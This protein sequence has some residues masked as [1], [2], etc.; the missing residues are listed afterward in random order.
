MKYTSKRHFDGMR[1]RVNI[2][3]ISYG[4]RNFDINKFEEIQNKEYCNKPKGGLWASPVD[5]EHGWK[6]WC[7]T[8]QFRD[9]K[10]E[11]SFR[12]TLKD[13]ANIY[14]INR[15]DDC[16]DM[17]QV[18]HDYMKSKIYPD[19]EI[20]KQNGVDAIQ[21]NLSNDKTESYSDGLYF[22]LYGWDCDC[23]LVMNKNIVEVIK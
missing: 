10:E 15:P 6:D 7:E 23:I 22:T 21:F 11:D 5:A 4:I 9:C 1:E 3:Y 16:N 18:N 17:P 12:F 8:E 2:E 20:M 19:F 13:D 14:Y